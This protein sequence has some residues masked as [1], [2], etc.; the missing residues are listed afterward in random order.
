MK[1]SGKYGWDWRGE[2]VGGG[3]KARERKGRSGNYGYIVK[4]E[5]EREGWKEEC[6]ELC[7]REG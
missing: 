6:S 5:N 4:W 2:V 3:E 7:R 1:I